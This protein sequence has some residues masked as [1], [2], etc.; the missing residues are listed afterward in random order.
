TR[1]I[2][3]WRRHAMELVS[4]MLEAVHDLERW[5]PG[6][7]KWEAAAMMVG[8]RRYQHALDE[9][10]SLI[11]AWI[12]ELSKVNL[13]AIKSAIDRY[14]L[15]ADSMIPPKI[16]L[17]WEEVIEYTFLSDFD[18]LREGQEDIR[19]EIWASPAGCVAMDQHFKLLHADE[20][21][22]RL[23]IEL[24]RLVTYMT[25]KE[26]FLVHHKT[27]LRAEGED[28]LAYQVQVHQMERSRFNAQHMERLV[29]L[30]KE[31]GFSGSITA[32]VS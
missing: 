25:D 15:T 3:T 14:N 21:I 20:E 13:T 12:F 7:D 18:L 28:T 26:G 31:A 30:S 32:G 8:R 1:A 4:K 16:N 5:E 24:Q 11:V 22:I 2:E 29:K 10:E 27:R 6:T 19:G 9:L 17:S 23:N